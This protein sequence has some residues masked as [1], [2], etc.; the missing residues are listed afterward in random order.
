MTT[1]EQLKQILEKWA[2]P[3]LQENDNSLVFRYQ[4]SYVQANITGVDDTNAIALTLSGIFS[5]DNEQEMMLGLRTCN[6]LN[7][8]LLQVKLYI[9][10]D[11]DL[12]IAAEFFLKTPEDMEYLLTVALQSVIVAK[13]RFLQRYREIEEEAKLI[14]ELEQE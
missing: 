3:I 2:F 13:K 1:K 12:I 6:D 9:D 7:Y 4:M 11:S 14:S 10:S 8:N 5:A